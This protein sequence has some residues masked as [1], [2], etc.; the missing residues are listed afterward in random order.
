MAIVAGGTFACTARADLAGAS[1]TRSDDPK[2][3]VGH[4]STLLAL[5]GSLHGKGL[6]GR[7]H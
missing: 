1:N 3:S 6:L 4:Q 5:E 7:P 2:S